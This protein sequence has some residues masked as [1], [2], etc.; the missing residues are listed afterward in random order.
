MSTPRFDDI[1]ARFLAGMDSSSDPSTIG[2]ESYARGM[3]VVNRGGVLQCRPGY[4]CK[5]ALPTGNSQGA[6]VFRPLQGYEVLLYG[7]EGV[8]YASQYPFAESSVVPNVSFAPQA[9]QLFFQQA[10][11]NIRYNDDASLTLI[12]S[13]NVMVIQDGGLTAPAVYDGTTA[14]H[15]RG[16]GTIP[17]GG[18]MAWSGDR[19][20]VSQGTKLFAGDIANPLSFREPLYFATVLSFSLP[21][22]IT[23]LAEVPN[24]NL[25]QLLVFTESTTTLIQSGIRNREDWN[26]TPNFQ[27]ILFPSV[28]CVSARSITAHL[29]LLWWYST[30]GLT[31]LD[32]ASLTQQTSILPYRDDALA[33]SKGRLSQDL[34]GVAMAFFE[35]YL[36]VSTPYCDK[37]NRH[38][39]VLDNAPIQRLNGAAGA[40]WNSFWTGT[41]PVQWIYGSFAGREQIF[42]LSRDFDGQNR[43]WEAFTSD[44]LDDGCPI[45]W[46]V[47][48]RAINGGSLLLNKQFRYADVFL[49]ELDGEIDIGVFWAGASR[50][51][52]KRILSKR[53]K[54]S[55]GS[56]RSDQRIAAD[57]KIFA[58]KKQMR[59]IR[60]Q[61]A[62]Q[63]AVE[64][65]LSS[66]GVESENAEFIDDAFQL[67]IVG[68]GPGAVSGIRYYL[69][70]APG[71]AGSNSPNK[72]L[73][74]AVEQDETEE[75]FVRFDGAAAE[76]HTFAD[77]L[78]ELTT[79]LLVF[80]SNR[81]VTVTQSGV[82]SIMAG[83]GESVISQA[84]ADKI[85]TAVATKKAVNEL[86]VNLPKIVSLGLAL[87]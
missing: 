66:T 20:W 85:A 45:T 46:Y 21:G 14:E 77:A 2:Q 11:Q 47:E 55:K 84:D 51:K 3:N 16:G 43:L 50:G 60:T 59:T 40:A 23:A 48:T 52:Y 71:T 72:E 37:F 44:R 42:F 53:I 75:N 26:A 5:Q 10:Q 54:A 41:R 87:A 19:L 30:F 1:D 34:G 86:Q 57:S 28:G 65:S 69:E 18:A 12:P 56:I 61:D 32:A 83:Y 36:L 49:S 80:I 67:L 13:R 35:S 22:E 33:D 6:A 62:K 82:T 81:T 27:R 25:A 39:W 73:S 9:R 74:G 78:A 7:V 31:S 17:L 76:A 4:R 70:P 64:E 38:T 58:M 79:E 63:L 29:G 68:S 8:L 15:Q 24:S